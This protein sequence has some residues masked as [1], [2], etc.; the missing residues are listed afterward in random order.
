MT[1]PAVR[2][3]TP[4]SP[5]HGLRRARLVISVV[6][7]F[8]V[9]AALTVGYYVAVLRGFDNLSY[10]TVG[11]AFLLGTDGL[12][13]AFS[14]GRR[15]PTPQQ[16]PVSRQ[17]DVSAIIACYNGADVIGETLES[18]LDA[19]CPR[20][21]HRGVGLLHRR[22]GRSCTG[23]RR[24]RGGEPVQ[25]EQAVERQPGGPDGQHHLHP[26]HRRRHPGG[27]GADSGRVAR[28]GRRGGRLRCHADRD[29]LAWSIGCRP[30]STA[31]R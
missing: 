8:A 13:L 26:G 25:P 19:C 4:V 20:E 27:L 29:G 31:S 28:R 16:G 3:V 18:L 23:V 12:L 14:T 21:H 15:P 1:A 7:V 22:H 2:T 6:T 10:L 17:E 9:M 24:A 11:I 30:T 5:V